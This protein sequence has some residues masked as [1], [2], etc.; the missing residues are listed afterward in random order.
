MVDCVEIQA[1]NETIDREIR[2]FI[3]K[4][5]RSPNTLLMS[6][7]SSMALQMELMHYQAG[8]GQLLKYRGMKVDECLKMGCKVVLE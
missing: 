5:G 7:I 1:V 4:F 2:T 8:A 6:T 3:E